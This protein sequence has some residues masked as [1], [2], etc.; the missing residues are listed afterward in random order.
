MTNLVD[1][2]LE[3][4][5]RDQRA[6]LAK[7][8]RAR[9]GR[10]LSPYAADP[11]ALVTSGTLQI[12]TKNGRR[13]PLV[14][15]ACQRK[16]FSIIQNLR[17][18]SRPVRLYI[19]KF[20]Q[21]GVSTLCEAILYAMTACLPNRNAIVLADED[22]RSKYIH[23]IAKHYHEWRVATDPATTPTIK[24]SNAKELVFEM[25]SSQLLVLTA[26][27]LD[28]P[29]AKTYQYA[30]LSEIAFYDHLDQILQAFQGVPDHPDTMILMETTAHG[31]GTVAHQE[32]LKAVSGKTEWVGVFLPWYLMEEYQRP[33]PMYPADEIATD[34][35]GG[36]QAF[37]GEEKTL[38]AQIAADPDCVGL[39]AAAIQ[40]KLSWRR[41]A[42]VNKCQGK[43]EV[44][45]V[46][47]PSTADEAWAVSGELYYPPAHTRAQVP[48]PVLRCGYLVPGTPKPEFR[49]TRDGPIR[50][51]E[52]P[53][54]GETY[55]IP[56][57]ASEGIGQDECAA[58]VRSR[59]LNRTVAELVGDLDPD[60]LAHQMFYLSR[61]Y[62]GVLVPENNGV[63]VALV[64]RLRALSG[65]LWSGRVT[66]EGLQPSDKLGWSTTTLTRDLM[67][68]RLG[69]ELRDQSVTLSGERSIREI[70]QL[71]NAV[72]KPIAPSGG[73]DGLAICHMIASAV[74]ALTRT[75]L[76]IHEPGRRE[77]SIYKPPPPNMGFGYDA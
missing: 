19:L 68:S 53:E 40:A 37:L 51:F 6:D 22:E 10:T 61:W 77:A 14:L 21:G 52:W 76:R 57:D 13:I 30:H 4:L 33:G 49:D 27:N 38:A 39:D 23:E 42:I 47:Y 74:R 43:V 11:L 48:K 9:L 59:R 24:R 16:V 67:A 55:L 32:W 34:R 71:I 44:A 20:R 64:D 2:L 58:I 54:P 36:F 66:P 18:A 29:R 65:N 7:S 45:R 31:A 62:P 63:G 1:W 72:G 8:L 3:E 70:Q 50:I 28:A 25:L 15:N 26:K 75:T 73:Q 35:T 41:W 12:K 17:T 60:E 46:E 5:T 69:Q 56:G